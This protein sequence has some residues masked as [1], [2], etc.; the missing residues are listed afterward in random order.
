M[1]LILF[2]PNSKVEA[3]IERATAEFDLRNADAVMEGEEALPP[4]L[5]LVRLKVDT[6]GVTEMSNPVR[7]V[8]VWMLTVLSGVQ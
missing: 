5:P 6:T 7:F 1:R 8:F 3:L 2:K 4:M